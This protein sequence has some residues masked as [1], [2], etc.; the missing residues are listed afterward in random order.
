MGVF[1]SFFFF[2]LDAFWRFIGVFLFFWNIYLLNGG[3]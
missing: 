2:S 3:F 1:G